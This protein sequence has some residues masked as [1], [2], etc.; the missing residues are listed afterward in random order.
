[1]KNSMTDK[2]SKPSFA[3][4]AYWLAT[5]YAAKHRSDLIIGDS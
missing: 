4:S 2:G 1:M 3:T 5:L